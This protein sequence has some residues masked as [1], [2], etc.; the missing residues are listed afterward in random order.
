MFSKPFYFSEAEAKIVAKWEIGVRGYV[1]PLTVGLFSLIAIVEVLRLTVK[2]PFDPL[3]F[4][5]IDAA[6]IG[7]FCL[8]LYFIGRR[9]D[10]TARE[11]QKRQLAVDFNLEESRFA[12]VEYGG[13]VVFRALNSDVEKIDIGPNVIRIDGRAGAICLPRAQVPEEFIL[14]MQKQLGKEKFKVQKWM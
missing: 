13:K 4:T 3:V 2:L 8:M 5:G 9:V 6:A 12:V 1:T 11:I 7:V 10:M 14:L